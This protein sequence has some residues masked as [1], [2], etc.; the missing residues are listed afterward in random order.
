LAPNPAFQ[1]NFPTFSSPD[2]SEYPFL[3]RKLP[4]YK[5]SEKGAP[6]PYTKKCEIPTFRKKAESRILNLLSG[7]KRRIKAK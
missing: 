4:L 5:P 1:A 7:N 6:Q 3:Y 2:S